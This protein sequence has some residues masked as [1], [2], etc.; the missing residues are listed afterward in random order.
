[1]DTHDQVLVKNRDAKN[2]NEAIALQLSVLAGDYY[3]GL[4]YRLLAEIGEIGLI[5]TL[6]TAIKRINEA[7]MK[8]YY[9]DFQNEQELI[10]LLKI[11]HAGLYV[12]IAEY[13]NTSQLTAFIEDWLLANFLHQNRHHK[14]LLLEHF[15]NYHQP[16]VPVNTDRIYE[17]CIADAMDNITN[18]SKDLQIHIQSVLKKWQ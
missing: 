6:A 4:Y 14:Q 12:A 17:Q 11:V 10:G 3:S 7:K 8:L 15:F 2:E 13:I 9:H 1:M 5:S 18:H 16:A